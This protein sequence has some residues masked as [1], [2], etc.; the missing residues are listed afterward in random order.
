MEKLFFRSISDV[1]GQ[2][3]KL[4]EIF[5]AGGKILLSDISCFVVAVLPF[6][7]NT[8]KETF[9]LL[10]EFSGGNY[11]I[12]PYIMLSEELFLPRFVFVTEYEKVIF[13][14]LKNS[15][16]NA[17]LLLKP[18]FQFPHFV[19]KNRKIGVKVP[20]AEIKNIL[21]VLGGVAL[22]F[23]AIKNGV[24]VSNPELVDFADVVV[25]IKNF[26]PARLPTYVEVIEN[27]VVKVVS[28]G[29]LSKNEFQEKL[30]PLGFRIV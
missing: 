7:K 18:T 9:D 27:Y 28:E 29:F 15:G 3:A 24:P 22:C 8:L 10:Q 5:E 23:P 26:A 19:L 30:S 4:R 6:S 1:L 20:D 17:V 25:Q 21:R 16:V 12:A 11:N 14:L 13:E 2:A